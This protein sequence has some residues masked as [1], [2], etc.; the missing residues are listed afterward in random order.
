MGT[1][2]FEIKT[3]ESFSGPVVEFKKIV[4]D[5]NGNVLLISPGKENPNERGYNSFSID[6]H[7][8]EHGD[9]KFPIRKFTESIFIELL[10]DWINKSSFDLELNRIIN[11][12]EIAQDT[13]ALSVKLIC[14]RLNFVI[15]TKRITISDI[16]VQNPIKFKPL[17]LIDIVG[18]VEV[19]SELIRIK[20]S[21]PFNSTKAFSN[22]NV[23]SRNRSIA[24]FIDEID[25]IGGT[26]LPILP[27]DT[28]DKM[29][30]IKNDTYGTEPPILIYHNQFKDFFNNGDDYKSVQLIMILVGIPYCDQ[31]L[32][33]II[34]GNPNYEK[35]ENK[36]IIKFIGEI[37]DKREQ[38]LK[39]IT[40]ETDESKKREEYLK[41]SNS[42]FANIQS[43]GGGWKRMLFNIVQNEKK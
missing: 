40:D 11:K 20:S 4:H 35:K 32:K 42:V 43:L 33:W 34:F 13:I 27:G 12:G 19:Q 25:D 7:E 14:P 30:I 5:Q 26:A 23:L 31:L 22:L 18:K 39:E 28:K 24:F 41:L 37:C 21:N 8:I 36:V 1:K 16:S 29:F 9:E 38:E 3:Y 6:L 15:E 17:N 2:K 10:P